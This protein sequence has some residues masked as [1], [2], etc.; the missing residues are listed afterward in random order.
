MQG[1]IVYIPSLNEQAQFITVLIIELYIYIYI[2]VYI[3]QYI[4]TYPY[5]YICTHIKHLQFS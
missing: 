1:V 5:V 3:S 4:H 2:T